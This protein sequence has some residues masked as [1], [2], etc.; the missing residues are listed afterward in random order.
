MNRKKT[1]QI[2]MIIAAL[3]ITIFGAIYNAII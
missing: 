3:M 2:V 1:R